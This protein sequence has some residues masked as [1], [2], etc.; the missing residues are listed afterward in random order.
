M[1]SDHSSYRLSINKNSVHQR[2][3]YENLSLQRKEGSKEERQARMKERRRREGKKE[4]KKKG[5]RK[6]GKKEGTKKV[7][8]ARRK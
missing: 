2:V 4:R 3:L 5:G 8:K 7:R 1:G 6:A